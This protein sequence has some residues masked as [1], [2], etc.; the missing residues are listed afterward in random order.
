MTRGRGALLVLLGLLIESVLT[1][2]AGTATRSVD[3]ERTVDGT[4]QPQ[5]S[6]ALDAFR[7]PRTYSS[8]AAP[9]RLRIPAAR[10]DTAL[11]RLGRAGDGGI[12]VPSRPGVAGW[13][14][15]GPRPGQSGPAVVLGHVD[16]KRGPAVFFRLA[17]LRPGAA[18]YV[19]RADGSTARFRV[20]RLAQVP[21][22]RFPTDLVFA[23]TLEA[24]LR[25]VTCGGSIDPATRHYR[26][27]VI[28]FA[29]SA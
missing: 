14:A 9:V 25:L 26:D 13:Y 15:A 4:V 17:K 27:N 3:D 6:P 22:S 20:K 16:S 21:K 1:A 11:Q 18:V 2:C 7:S 12:Q 5:G 28:V 19:D 8:V 29:A 10:V 24:S 23:P